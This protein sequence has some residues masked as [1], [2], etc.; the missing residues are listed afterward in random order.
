MKVWYMYVLS[1]VIPITNYITL[2]LP[3]LNDLYIQQ[4]TMYT[5]SN[6]LL[7]MGSSPATKLHGSRP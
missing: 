5:K 7:M 2:Y 4:I 3:K 1:T 6:K